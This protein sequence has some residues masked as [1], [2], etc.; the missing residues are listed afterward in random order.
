MSLNLTRKV[1]REAKE[2]EL[3][4]QAGWVL[5]PHSGLGLGLMIG[6]DG[7]WEQPP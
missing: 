6:S 4:G 1:L 2:L 3:G 7:V 5:S